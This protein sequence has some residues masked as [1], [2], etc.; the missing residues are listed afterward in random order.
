MLRRL[1]VLSLVA[2]SAAQFGRNRNNEH[3]AG[4]LGDLGGAQDGGMSDVDLA[5]AGWEQLGKNPEKMQDLMQGFKDPEVWA[6]AQEMLKDPQYMAAAQAKLAEIQAKAQANGL[7]D[8]NGNPVP[9]AASQ[10]S[11]GMAG[12]LN[13]MQSMQG[14]A[15]GAA[16]GGA[17]DWELDNLEKHKAGDMNAAE[18]G[19]AQLKGAM[20]DPS[21][22]AEVANMMK[23]VRPEK[24]LTTH[25]PSPAPAPPPPLP[26]PPPPLAP[27]HAPPLGPSARPAGQHG[28]APKDDG[29]PELPAAGAACRRAD[30]GVRRAARLLLA[31]DSG[32]DAGGVATDDGR[33]DGRRRRRR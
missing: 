7:L 32:E 10:A 18:L 9:G 1:V 21:V 15:G 26:S 20:K 29:R 14:A 23:D 5:M 17:R 22:M 11:G 30:E 19:M 3:A 13:A 27:A 6:K 28:G 12:M 25:A 16:A 24:P 33:R 4:S 2:L 8:A 31:R